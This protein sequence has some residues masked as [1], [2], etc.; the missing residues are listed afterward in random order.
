MTFL[1][2]GRNEEAVVMLRQAVERDPNDAAAY[3]KL[4]V[5]NRVLC[6]FSKLVLN[7]VRGQLSVVRCFPCTVQQ[8]SSTNNQQR[9]LTTND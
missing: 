2:T 6:L 4:G 9:Q 8:L 7:S 1:E 3:G 5:A